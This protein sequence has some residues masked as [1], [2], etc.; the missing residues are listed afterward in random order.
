ML[1]KTKVRIF[2]DEAGFR[3]SLKAKVNGMNLPRD[4]F[5]VDIID[6]KDFNDSLTGMTKRQ[7]QFRKEGNWTHDRSNPL[8]DFS[9]LII[10]YDLFEAEPFLDA[11]RIAYL[12]R[13]FT[14]CG[15]IVVLNRFGHNPFDLTLKD[16]PESFADL[17]IGQDQLN[18][19]F[20]WGVGENEFAPWYW[21]ALPQYAKNYEKKFLDVKQAIESGQSI[22]DTL[23]FSKDIRDR[24]PTELDRFLG[25]ETNTW[26]F[27]QFVVKSGHGLARKDGAQVFGQDGSVRDPDTI[28]RIAAARIGKWLEF[29][30]LPEL[31]I[32]VDAPHLAGRL[33]SLVNGDS[34]D[35]RNAIVVRHSHQIPMLNTVP[36]EKFRLQNEHW[37]SRPAWLWRDFLNRQT[38]VI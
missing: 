18:N 31:D 38:S 37:L 5:D 14:T 27:E 10:D 34:I 4:E 13:C 26:L 30:L 33:P 9:I 17:D 6:P 16:H 3:Q 1:T 15:I 25:S 36:I 8:D 11:E 19:P 12:A 32:L 28:A 21:P 20:L 22:W 23:G 2:D 35:D 7:Q 24:I 29:Q